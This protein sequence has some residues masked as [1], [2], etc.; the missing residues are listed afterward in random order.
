MLLELLDVVA[1]VRGLGPVAPE[2]GHLQHLGQ[3]GQ[4]AVG[5]V[6]RG[7]EAVVELGDVVGL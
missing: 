7:A 6:G 1:G 4:Y 3:D 5:L 2:F